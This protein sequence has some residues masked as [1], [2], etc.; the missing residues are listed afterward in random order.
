MYW[1]MTNALMLVI[2]FLKPTYMY[3]IFFYGSVLHV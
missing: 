1:N 3:V 2:T